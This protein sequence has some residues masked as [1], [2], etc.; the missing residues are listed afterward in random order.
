MTIKQRRYLFYFI[1]IL[2]LVSGPYTVLK[3]ANYERIFGNDILLL[4]TLQRISGLLAFV[5]IGMQ[6]FMGAFMHKLTQIIGARSFKLHIV[7]GIGSVVFI[8]LH[9]ILQTMIDYRVEGVFRSF[10]QPVFSRPDELYYT[11]GR[12]AFV[13]LIVTILAAYFRTKINLRRVWLK[14]HILNYIAFYFIFFH[15][16]R[17]GSDV[18]TFPFNIVFYVSFVFATIAVVYRAYNYLSSKELLLSVTSK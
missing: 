7:Q 8:I 6:I 2:I 18:K 11:F 16:F 15:A 17:L 13:L 1:W 3:T 5:L 12:V 10:L 9:P 14:L 4:S